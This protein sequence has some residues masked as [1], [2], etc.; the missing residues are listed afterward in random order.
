LLLK[1][2][3]NNLDRKFENLSGF[4]KL[5]QGVNNDLFATEFCL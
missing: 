1:V 2:F 5:L 3:F 4:Y